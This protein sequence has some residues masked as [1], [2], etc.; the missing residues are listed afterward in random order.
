[1]YFSVAPDPLP[2]RFRLSFFTTKSI[3]EAVVYKKL[4]TDDVWKNSNS[5][6][7]GT[8]EPVFIEHVILPPTI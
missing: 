3:C 4:P 1:M 8:S 5:A 7:A 2:A 6:P